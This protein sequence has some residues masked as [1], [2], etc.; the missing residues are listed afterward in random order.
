MK[1]GKREGKANY[2]WTNNI[3]Y[4]VGHA[5]VHTLRVLDC[6]V[7]EGGGNN[8]LRNFGT[9]LSGDTPQCP[10][11][12][13]CSPLPSELQTKQGKCKVHPCTGTEA[14]YKPYGP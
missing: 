8:L 1:H 4:I 11:G 10:R 5:F 12:L 7:A 6:V 14:L 13:D 9:C 2:F 3:A